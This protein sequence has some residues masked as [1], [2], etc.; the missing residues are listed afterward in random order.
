MLLFVI[1]LIRCKCFKLCKISVVCL[2]FIVNRVQFRFNSCQTSPIRRHSSATYSE[3]P[4]SSRKC[5][6]T[7]RTHSKCFELI[8]D[9]YILLLSPLLLL[10]VDTYSSQR[11]SNCSEFNATRLEVNQNAMKF[12]PIM[13]KMSLNVFCSLKLVPTCFKP[14]FILANIP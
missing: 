10:S 12:V 3:C 5:P 4:N 6:E 13:L 1:T 8:A 11:H 2:E 9:R 7:N 14:T